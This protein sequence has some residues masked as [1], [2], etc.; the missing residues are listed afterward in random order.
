MRMMRQKL[1]TRQNERVLSYERRCSFPV[2]IAEVD[3]ELDPLTDTQ[4][5]G[6]APQAGARWESEVLFQDHSMR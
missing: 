2:A 5:R 6:L 4:L 1:I 3:Q